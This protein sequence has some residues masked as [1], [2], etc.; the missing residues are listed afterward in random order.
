VIPYSFSEAAK[1]AGANVLADIG[2]LNVPYQ[3]TTIS[4]LRESASGAP[5]QI[6]RL[7]RGLVDAVLLIHDP[8][9]KA[10]IREI[11]RK[12]FRFPNAEDAEASYQVLAQMATIEIMPDPVAWKLVQR[13]VAKINPKVA[14][15]DLNQLMNPLFVRN[16]EETGFLPAARKRL[17]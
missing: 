3:G 10:D 9:A 2:K 17:R 13:I 16:L 11:L 5:D 14:Q 4:F 8:R 1:R 7:L 15:V 12:N 6:S